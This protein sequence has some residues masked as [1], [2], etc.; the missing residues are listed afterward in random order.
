MET[1]YGWRESRCIFLISYNQIT[2]NL[3]PAYLIHAALRPWL[4]L[5]A[6]I[7]DELAKLPSG[8]GKI[9]FLGPCQPD[10]ALATRFSNAQSS[11]R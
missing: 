6:I 11:D 3:R 7:N 5:R 2:P 8:Q 9:A 10:G 1:L 4:L